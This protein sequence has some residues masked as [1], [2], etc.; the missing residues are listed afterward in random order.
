MGTANIYLSQMKPL[1]EHFWVFTA[2]FD[3][4]HSYSSWIA[5]KLFFSATLPLRHI[6][7]KNL[8]D[9]DLLKQACGF[10]VFTNTT[11]L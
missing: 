2:D 5:E 3:Y 7:E 4:I 10:S 8:Y 1:N 11:E 6:K 9:T